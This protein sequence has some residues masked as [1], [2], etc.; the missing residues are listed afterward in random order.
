MIQ[1]MSLLIW[2]ASRKLHDRM[3]H[4]IFRSPMNFFDTTP[5]GRILNRFSRYVPPATIILPCSLLTSWTV[6]FTGWTRLL[7][8]LSIW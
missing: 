7:H 2:Q 1:N 6:T 4:A 5:T 3:A 8:G